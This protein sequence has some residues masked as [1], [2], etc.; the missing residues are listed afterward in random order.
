MEDKIPESVLFP[1]NLYEQVNAIDR[2]SKP[3]W[4]MKTGFSRLFQV[5]IIK[6]PALQSNLMSINTNDPVN[7]A[8]YIA[9]NRAKI[10]K[11]QICF[12]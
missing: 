8:G 2:F 12:Y 7:R 10:E 1:V 5:L 6:K 4:N 9:N 3:D 11:Q